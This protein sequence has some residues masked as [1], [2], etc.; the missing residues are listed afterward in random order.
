M[1]QLKEYKIPYGAIHEIEAI[2]WN[3]VKNNLRPDSCA[4]V[5]NPKVS[6]RFE[7]PYQRNKM[8]DTPLKRKSY[9]GSS[10][11]IPKIFVDKS[12]NLS[13]QKKFRPANEKRK[14]LEG[15][16]LFESNIDGCDEDEDREMNNLFIDHCERLQERVSMVED[17]FVKLYQQCWHQDEAQRYSA[18]EVTETLHSFIKLL[19]F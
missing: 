12:G 3:V 5:E 15:R 2:I 8:N 9:K 4:S 13:S 19:E 7:S 16:K 6:I 18:S 14:S 17:K 10:E 1:W 11:N